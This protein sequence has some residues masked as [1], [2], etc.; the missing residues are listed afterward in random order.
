[1]ERV[2]AEVENEMTLE[3]I[4]NAKSLCIYSYGQPIEIVLT[5]RVIHTSQENKTLVEYKIKGHWFFGVRRWV[6]VE[7]IDIISDATQEEFKK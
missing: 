3:E 6:S 1:V 5:K 7:R 2:D 4:L